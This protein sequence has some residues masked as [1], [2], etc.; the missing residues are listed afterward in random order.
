M[1][2]TT[3]E[4]CWRQDI[5]RRDYL[6]ALAGSGLLYLGIV[7]LFYDSWI[8]AAGLLV[9]WPLYLR[10][11][12]RK[13]CREK[14]EDFC[15]QFE[16][17]LQAL[18][19]SLR[20]G[21]AVENGIRETLREL[22]LLYPEKARI[23]REFQYMARQLGMNQPVHQVLGAFAR[24]VPQP[25]TESFVSVFTAAGWAGG[26]AVAVIQNTVDTLCQKLEVRRE[27]QTLIAAKRLE[28][29]VMVMVPLGM[30]LYMR[31]AF[32]TFMG[33]LY[34]NLAGGLLMTGCLAVYL[35][36]WWYGN[37]IVEIAL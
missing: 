15:R 37:R 9:F 33:T 24:R 21:Y 4:N 2:F 29:K 5:E 16:D 8:F 3:E 31:M 36:A 27:I 32:G 30:L 18:S 1:S 11:F 20:A 34:G 23:C 6:L 14:E 35:G 19:A 12:I 13:K 26:D 10:G 25:E 28:F 17:A 22:K 7:W